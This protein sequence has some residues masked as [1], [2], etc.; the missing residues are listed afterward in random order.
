[1]VWYKG[2]QAVTQ[3]DRH[4]IIVNEDGCEALLITSAQLGDG[5]SVGCI[6]RNRSGEASAMVIISRT[7]SP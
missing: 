5:G 3:D 2:G 7:A 1:M 6:A 4:K